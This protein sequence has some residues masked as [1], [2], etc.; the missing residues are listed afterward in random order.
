MYHAVVT[1]LR[2]VRRIVAIIGSGRQVYIVF[3][4]I[5][6]AI[7]VFVLVS[8]GICLVAASTLVPVVVCI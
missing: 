4:N 1:G 3:A 6:L 2:V 7:R 5:A 8:S